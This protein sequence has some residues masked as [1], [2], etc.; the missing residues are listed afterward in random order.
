[1]HVQL[2]LPIWLLQRLL[3]RRLLWPVQHQLLTGWRNQR[4]RPERAQLR[5]LSILS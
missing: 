1:M 5:L 4:L 2:Q 3:L